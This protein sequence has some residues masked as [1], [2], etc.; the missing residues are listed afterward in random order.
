MR[1]LTPAAMSSVDSRVD[2]C[3][4]QYFGAF[5]SSSGSPNIPRLE[6]TFSVPDPTE[7]AQRDCAAAR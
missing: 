2:Y 6:H 7:W 3:I 4:V 5:D 1:P